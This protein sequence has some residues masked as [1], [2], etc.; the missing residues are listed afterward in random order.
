MKKF[1]FLIS[2]LLIQ[3]LVSQSV[4]AQYPMTYDYFME[5]GVENFDYGDYQEALHYFKSAQ[6]INPNGKESAIY[7]S[8]VKDIWEKEKIEKSG[9]DKKVVRAADLYKWE[10]GLEKRLQES[11]AQHKRATDA[12]GQQIEFL[13]KQNQDAISEISREAISIFS[14]LSVIEV[15]VC[16]TRDS[17]VAISALVV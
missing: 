11:V 12:L 14:M 6:V 1:F 5:L 13:L 7:I 4:F 16:V 2:F 15:T 3:I 8:F 9:K 10:R 17:P